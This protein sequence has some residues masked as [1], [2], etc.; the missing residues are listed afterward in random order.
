MS[1]RETEM[2]GSEGKAVPNKGAAKIARE[3]TRIGKTIPLTH[4]VA[5]VRSGSALQVDYYPRTQKDYYRELLLQYKAAA[6]ISDQALRDRIMEAE[7]RRE[8]ER[9][10]AARHIGPS[11]TVRDERLSF[12]TFKKWMAHGATHNLSDARFRFIDRFVA[13][14][15]RP[16]P[17]TQPAMAIVAARRHYHAGAFRDALGE[18][19]VEPY[20]KQVLATHTNIALLGPAAWVVEKDGNIIHRR[21]KTNFLLHLSGLDT[22]TAHATLLTNQRA[23][24]DDEGEGELYYPFTGDNI[25]E[26]A[27]GYAVITKTLNDHRLR[28]CRVFTNL[29]ISRRSGQAYDAAFLSTASASTA[30]FT[31]D[32]EFEM[33]DANSLQRAVMKSMAGLET[34]YIEYELRRI[35]PDEQLTQT[36]EK[37]AFASVNVE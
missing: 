26:V 28:L 6:G 18:H 12:E 36:I 13:K 17:D 2:S 19:H 33:N 23:L 8:T 3:R 24:A 20:A 14:A 5:G 16:Q 21:L 4:K 32:F 11:Q 22:G 31:L 27:H 35:V 37:F 29:L 34:K 1:K 25:V 7:D 15:V 9:Q 10:R 30:V